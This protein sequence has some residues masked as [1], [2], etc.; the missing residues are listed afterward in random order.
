M[1]KRIRFYQVVAVSGALALA[2][3]AFAQSQSGASDLSHPSMSS[4]SHRGGTSEGSHPSMASPS[5][6]ETSQSL[7]QQGKNMKDRVASEA[8]RVLQQRIREALNGQTELATAAQNIQLEIDDG[9][10]TMSGSVA[11]AQ[12]KNDIATTVSRVAGVKK[13]NNRIQTASTSSK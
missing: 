3:P 13:V 4:P 10:V 5:H 8:D 1:R 12:Q 6:S 9:E 11:T 2:V 7:Q